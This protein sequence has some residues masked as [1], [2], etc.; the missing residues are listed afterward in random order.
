M[1]KGAI[2]KTCN[3]SMTRLMR[4]VRL[5]T[6]L[7]AAMIFAACALQAQYT[8]PTLPQPPASG[9]A[10]GVSHAAKE[11]M[12]D[13]AQ[14]NLTEIAMA[15]I[16]ET[17]AQNTAA[18]ELAHMMRSDHQ[19]NYDLLRVMAQNHL[20][21]LDSKPDMMN[22]HA[23]HRLQK[24]SD[25]DFDKD[26]TKVMLKDHV[27]CITRFDKAL[28]DIE[29]PYV[30]EYAQNTLPALRKH[31]RHAEDAARSVGVDE[32]TISSI[33]KDLPSDELLRIASKQN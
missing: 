10:N 32:G 5:G 26:Y 11:F 25:A 2:M 4:V 13:A 18:K 12:Q 33:L 8:G 28:M 1:Q 6:A 30:R 24:A 21:V 23:I 17:R 9:D 14:A 3:D 19:Q 27:K 29:E 16:A 15:N 7:S 22:Q 20:I 31:L